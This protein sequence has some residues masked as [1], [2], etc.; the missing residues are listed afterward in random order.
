MR[1]M[2][3]S[4][5]KSSGIHKVCLGLVILAAI[6]TGILAQPASA[7]AG[8]QHLFQFGINGYLGFPQG[9]FKQ[10]AGN[11][12]PGGDFGL[13]L[14]VYERLRT[15]VGTRLIKKTW[16][17]LADLGVRYIKGGQAEYLQ[18]SSIFREDGELY[19]DVKESRT[20]LVSVQL[21]ITF[22]F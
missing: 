7:G 5:N 14:C 22:K 2:P 21:E 19:Y 12:S 10:N 3:Y 8:A 11:I 15:T 9:A 20:D 17:I 4:L 18:E 1:K 6:P 13:M 16:G